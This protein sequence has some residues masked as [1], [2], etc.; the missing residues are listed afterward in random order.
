MTKE[1]LFTVI[2]TRK[3]RLDLCI[4][5]Y[6]RKSRAYCQHLI[7]SGFVFKENTSQPI[8]SCSYTVTPEEVLIVH[9]RPPVQ[10]TIE[11]ENI[12]LNVVYED[13]HVIVVNKHAGMVVHPA[14]GHH[15]GTLVHALLY[16]CQ[17]SLSGINGVTKPGIVHR[18]D[19]DTSGL[20]IAA[21]N[22]EAHL[23]LSK[24]IENRTMQRTYAT[25]CHGDVVPRIMDVMC[26]IGRHPTQRTKM[27]VTKKG[28]QAHTTLK[29]ILAAKVH[30][31]G[32]VSLVQCS[33]HSGRTHQIR[34]HCAHQ[35]HPVLNDTLYGGQNITLQYPIKEGRQA[36]HA[37]SLS[38]DHPK[39]QERLSFTATPP[40][41]LITLYNSIAQGEVLFN[42]ER[43]VKEIFPA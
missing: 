10:P 14:P 4:T 11:P 6:T 17:G 25:F 18:L 13:A 31:L 8:T 15:K 34:V 40:E 24:Q 41:D 12:P 29:T 2:A 16:H 22:N 23:S 26:P 35:H 39:T 7:K 5:E 33:L 30:H 27:S 32:V 3:Q 20:I 19:K 9:D 43:L 38:F 36:L 28:R 37:H 1:K 42:S 21:K